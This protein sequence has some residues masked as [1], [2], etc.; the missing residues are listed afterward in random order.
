LPLPVND[1]P[2]DRDASPPCFIAGGIGI[3]PMIG[4][5]TRR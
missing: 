4:M 5:A 3:T 1:F 2:L